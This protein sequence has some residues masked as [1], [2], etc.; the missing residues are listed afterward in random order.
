MKP[1]GKA[2]GVTALAW[3]DFGRTTP[4]CGKDNL[5]AVVTAIRSRMGA[6]AQRG[7]RDHAR[8][9]VD[10][11][12]TIGGAEDERDHHDIMRA[13]NLSARGG[14]ASVSLSSPRI[15]LLATPMPSLMERVTE[16]RALSMF[17]IGGYNLLAITSRIV[18]PR[19]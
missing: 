7:Q 5:R 18:S 1:T 13:A 4:V 10:S 2:R 3:I 11:Y 15:P 8:P 19:L 16:T 9:G 6:V 17:P 14:S 12:Q